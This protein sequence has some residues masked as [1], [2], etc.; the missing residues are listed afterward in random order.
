MS[1]P[2]PEQTPLS[3]PYWDALKAGRLTFQRCRKCNHAWLPPR[4]D[5]P[6]CLASEPEWTTA[7][8]KGR[9]ISWV[10]YHHAYHEASRRLPYNVTLV[11][12]R[13]PAVITNIVNRMPHR[14]E[15]PVSCNRG[16]NASRSRFALTYGLFVTGA[17]AASA[18]PTRGCFGA[19]RRLGRQLS[20]AGRARR[21][22]DRIKASG[23]KHS[24][25]RAMSVTRTMCC[26]CSPRPT[27]NS[28][29]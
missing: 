12:S 17:A 5:C 23:A 19:R 28:A 10:I 3:Q 13:G 18:A 9:V 24:R 1:F 27:R 4:A 26:A 16:R 6:E 14:G 7:S 20:C 11:D 15:R 21:R 22:R 8:G 29:R 25:C 2:L